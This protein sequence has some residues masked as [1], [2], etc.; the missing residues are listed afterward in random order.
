MFDE[1][2]PTVS[3]RRL[4]PGGGVAER[5]YARRLGGR[6]RSPGGR[7][8]AELR[9]AAGPHRLPGCRARRATASS[10]PSAARGQRPGLGRRPALRRLPPRAASTVEPTR[11]RRRRLMSEPLARDRPLWQIWIADRASTTVASASSARRTTAWSTASPPSSSARCCSTRRRSRRR[12]SP[13]GWRPAA[14]SRAARAAGS[15]R[16][17]TWR[18]TSSHR[19]TLRAR[20]CASPRR[21]VEIADRGVRALGALADSSRPARPSGP[22]NRPISPAAP[23]SLSTGRS[24][25]CCAIKAPL[26]RDASTTSCSPRRRAACGASWP[27]AARPPSP[28]KAMVPVNVREADEEDAL[29]NRISFMFVDL[30]CDEPDPVRAAARRS[31]STT[32]ERKRARRAAGRRRRASARSASRPWAVQ[33]L[34]SRLIASPRTFN[35]V[36]SNIPGP[37]EPLYMAAA[38]CA[39]P[40]R[41]SRSPT[42]T[43]SRSGSRRRRSACFGLYADR[44]SLPD[45]DDLAD[46]IDAAIDELLD[47]VERA[48]RPD[49]ARGAPVAPAF[50]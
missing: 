22:L 45:V 34:A 20:R 38:S 48:V 8:R 49:T 7:A 47:P 3:A 4:V 33:R 6:A 2:H 39:R 26:R 35:L 21:A 46:C 44:D 43:R 10:S 12:P 11:R 41:S 15:R 29:G 5:T 50:G 9:A 28:L 25:T 40:T 16:G 1:R 42:A 24:R 32:S 37:R 19:R 23:G 18:A 31:T 36:V 14:G 27:S 30:P 17:A 13:D